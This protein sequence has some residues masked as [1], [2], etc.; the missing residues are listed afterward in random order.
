MEEGKSKTILVRH[1]KTDK[2]R[3]SGEGGRHKKRGIVYHEEEKYPGYPEGHHHHGRGSSGSVD[4]YIKGSATS[5]EY[6]RRMH[7]TQEKMREERM[8]EDSS[9]LYKIVAAALALI[10]VLLST[11]VFF[12]ASRED[13]INAPMSDFANRLDRNSDGGLSA[14]I[15]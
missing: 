4:D 14:H 13:F 11:V 1:R 5:D 12:M 10:I 6:R 9:Y 3:V 7:E 15:D 2:N 8:T